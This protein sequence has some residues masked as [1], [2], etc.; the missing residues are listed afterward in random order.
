[1]NLPDL[2]TLF[3]EKGGDERLLTPIIKELFKKETV[4]REE[5]YDAMHQIRLNAGDTP[6]ND[7]NVRNRYEVMYLKRSNLIDAEKT[8]LEH[9]EKEIKMK[10]TNLCEDKIK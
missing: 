5:W 9:L 10:S 4:A 8:T 1:M 3:L 2:E 6:M 7:K